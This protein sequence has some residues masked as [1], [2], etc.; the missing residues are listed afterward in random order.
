MKKKEIEKENTD[1]N[2]HKQL[3]YLHIGILWHHIRKKKQ[4]NTINNKPLN[5]ECM[6]MPKASFI[7]SPFQSS[8][9]IYMCITI[10]LNCCI[11]CA[12]VILIFI[13]I[14]KSRLV[15]EKKKKISFQLDLFIL[16]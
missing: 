13:Y 6:I 12:D 14:D 10:V 8:I 3:V 9:Y 7:A 16:K 4:R 2:A 15:L 1:D 5:Y 11:K